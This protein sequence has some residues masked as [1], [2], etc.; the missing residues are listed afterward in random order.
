MKMILL[1]F[2]F[3]F[4]KYECCYPTFSPFFGN[5]KSVAYNRDGLLINK[6]GFWVCLYTRRA[7]KRD[8]LV[9]V[10]LR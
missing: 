8:A 7:T 5:H 1:F 2:S 9:L 6:S 4:R 10:T 3:F